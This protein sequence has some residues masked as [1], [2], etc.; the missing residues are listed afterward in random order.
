MVNTTDLSFMNSTN[1]TTQLQGINDLS[2]GWLGAFIPMVVFIVIFSSLITRMETSTK[3]AFA[4]SSFA[5][6][7]ITI[8]L[9]LLGFTSWVV[10]YITIVM[11]LGSILW[12]FLGG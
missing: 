1:L 5:T 2:N 4:A 9:V 6:F 7:V 11:V 12:S 3:Q 10:F 8:P